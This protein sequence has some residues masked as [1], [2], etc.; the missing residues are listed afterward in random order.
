MRFGVKSPNFLT[1]KYCQMCSVN[2]FWEHSYDVYGHVYV[3]VRVCV[4]VCVC[5]C[6]CVGVGVGVG[7][8]AWI[9]KTD[10]AFLS[11]VSCQAWLPSS[12]SLA[13]LQ[14][15]PVQWHT[16]FNLKVR[17]LNT[18]QCEDCSV[19]GCV[20]VHSRMSV[21]DWYMSVHVVCMCVCV[22]GCHL[23]WNL[24]NVSGS[25]QV[26][27]YPRSEFSCW[28]SFYRDECGVLCSQF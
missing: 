15:T 25:L 12:S 13:A 9:R 3:R 4:C 20:C 16:C 18:R 2:P 7:V 1:T 27:R 6:M 14:T 10:R 24:S 19:C 22:C 21:C 28:R 8:R 23:F 11:R 26:L 17:E 5:V